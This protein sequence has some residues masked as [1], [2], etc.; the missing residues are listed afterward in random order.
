[1]S[2]TYTYTIRMSYTLAMLESTNYD[3]FD[4]C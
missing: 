2:Y 1:M 4:M 3:S